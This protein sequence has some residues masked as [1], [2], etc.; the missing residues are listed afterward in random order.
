MSTSA[1]KP[2]SND[3]EMLYAAFVWLTT[4]ARRL[5]LER[6]VREAA[7][8]DADAVYRVCQPRRYDETPTAEQIA[9]MLKAIS[10]MLKVPRSTLRRR[11]DDA[12]A[13]PAVMHA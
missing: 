11:L 13:R 2:F 6:D 10:A 3:A 1:I 8:G 7:M 5:T 12:E 9:T 4:R